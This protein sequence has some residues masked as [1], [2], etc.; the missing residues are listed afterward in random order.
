[1]SRL[2][3]FVKKVCSHQALHLCRGGHGKLEEGIRT[4]MKIG[5]WQGLGGTLDD[6]LAESSVDIKDYE[7]FDY[8]H[9]KI[10]VPLNQM[11]PLTLLL[12]PIDGPTDGT[13]DTKAGGW[14]VLYETDKSQLGWAAGKLASAHHEERFKKMVTDVLP[15]S[16]E[17]CEQH[18]IIVLQ[19]LQ[20]VQ[21]QTKI[22]QVQK[23]QTKKNNDAVHY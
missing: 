13:A 15:G 12:P 4:T 6:C 16:A 10:I 17:D 20:N 22:D 3:A 21:L 18:V 11:A 1:M 14:R 9:L 19:E 5:D 8:G 7:Y 2:T 23:L